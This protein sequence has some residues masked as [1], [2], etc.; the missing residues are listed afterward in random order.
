ML[1]GSKPSLR[2][3]FNS[4]GSMCHTMESPY[5]IYSPCL[6]NLKWW[7]QGRKRQKELIPM[8]SKHACLMIMWFLSSKQNYTALSKIPRRYGLLSSLNWVW[9]VWQWELLPTWCL[10]G[11]LDLIWTVWSSV[12]SVLINQFIQYLRS[13]WNEWNHLL[14]IQRWLK[15]SCVLKE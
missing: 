8:L 10:A 12:N 4:F 3:P 15:T 6:H 5:V 13:S 14:Q 7:R 9:F 2:L 1:V 11:L